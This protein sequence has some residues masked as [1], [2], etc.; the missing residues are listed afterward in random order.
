VLDSARAR[1]IDSLLRDRY[2]DMHCHTAG[3]GSGGS[4]CFTA[5]AFR[6]SYKYGIYLKAFG[7]TEKQLLDSGDAFVIERLSQK[8]SRSKYVGAA[9]VLALDGVYDSAGSLDTARTQLYIPND[10]V[11]AETR[12]HPN[13]LFGAS[14]NPKRK[15]AL[16]ALAKAKADG[17]V[18]V[19]WL[20]SIMDFDPADSAF[21]PFYRA[22]KAAGLPLLSHTGKESSFLTAKNEL[23]DPMRLELPLKLGVT[24]IAAHVGTPGKSEGEA[25]VERALRLLG[26]YPNL[27]ADVSSLTQI[28]KLSY[29]GKILPR[30]EG[31]G[32]LIYGSD[33]PLIETVL[34]SPWFFGYKLPLGRVHRISG[35]ENAWDRDVEL[36]RALGVPEEVFRGSEELL[37]KEG[38]RGKGLGVR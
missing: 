15:D 2:L 26:R 7:V 37:L 9:V 33:Y 16:A 24:V 34:V 21:I 12:K 31:K 13:L 3:I 20:P 36:K 4:G 35:I 17:A 28:N 32:K 14:I 18:L 22:L 30:P 8:L 11:A 1:V 27:H 23:C 19:K 6:D 38:V 29:L 10:F 25:N 5:R